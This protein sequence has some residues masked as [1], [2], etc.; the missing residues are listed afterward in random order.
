MNESSV[1]R[2]A[3]STVR[4]FIASERPEKKEGIREV[5][6]TAEVAHTSKR[7]FVYISYWNLLVVL[8]SGARKYSDIQRVCDLKIINFCHFNHWLKFKNLS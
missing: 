4:G 7:T 2:L 1:I 8:Y 3:E 5:V 6:S